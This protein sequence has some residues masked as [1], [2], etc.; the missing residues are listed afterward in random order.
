VAN[1]GPTSRDNITGRCYGCHQR[2]TDKDRQAG[3]LGSGSRGGNGSG[4]EPP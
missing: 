1:G 4:R 3:L 2:K